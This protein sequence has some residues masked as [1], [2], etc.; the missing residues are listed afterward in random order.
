MERVSP[1]L[2][3]VDP[4]LAERERSRLPHPDDTLARLEALVQTSRMASLARRSMEAPASRAPDSIESPRRISRAGRRRSVAFAGGATA[5]A[6]VIALLV[7][8]RVDLG[9]APAGADTV[10]LEAP[11]SESAPEAPVEADEA[12]PS[13][14]DRT[15][16]PPAPAPQRFA[17]APASGAAS[18]HVELFLGSSKVFETGTRQPAVTVPARWRFEGRTRTLVPGDYRWY[19][20]PVRSGR[21][22]GTAIVQ[23]RLVVPPR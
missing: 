4:S 7:G 11:I 20:W 19:V 6:L 18:Y 2:V 15:P 9:G 13:P 3:L 21:R 1:E 10:V 8:V 23:A 22:S 12:S 5:G 17:W 16:P 14:V